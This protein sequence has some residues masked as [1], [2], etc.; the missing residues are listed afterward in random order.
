[1]EATTDLLC[2]IADG[3]GRIVHCT[4]DALTGK[5]KCEPK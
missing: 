3:L 5:E 1:M 2:E 4:V